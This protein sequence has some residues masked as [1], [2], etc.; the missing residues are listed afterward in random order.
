MKNSVFF[1]I[2]YREN[3]KMKLKL[4][5]LYCMLISI[6]CYSDDEEGKKIK[7]K[8]KFIVNKKLDVNFELTDRVEGRIVG[9]TPA[10]EGQAPY[11]CSLQLKDQPKSNI[12]G[13]AIISS[14]WVLTE[15]HCLRSVI[16][17]VISQLSFLYF[18]PFTCINIL[19]QS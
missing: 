13:C 4:L 18:F 1:H 6:S 17:M 12:C 5:V 11:Q 9:G 7:I 19:I 14:E 3:D 8:F 16:N 10:H 2:L 15:A